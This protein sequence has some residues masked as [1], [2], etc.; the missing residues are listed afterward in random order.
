MGLL[1]VGP[2]YGAGCTA[3][4]DDDARLACFD[5]LAE[6]VTQ[7]DPERRLACY[8]AASARRAA[9]TP[10]PAAPARPAEAPVTRERRADEAFPVRGARDDEE[11]AE[12]RLVAE[13][14]EVRSDPRGLHYLTLDNG[15][16]WREL[17]KGR[18][19][20]EEGDRVEITPGILGSVNLKVE[21]R[22]GYV[23]VRRVE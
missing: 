20:F 21:G 6:C 5:R 23:K 13:I 12:E 16:I 4:A 8:D 7:H 3:E 11:R 1:M 17:S 9:A 10:A 14:V 2:A 22:S 18:I 19:R 15:Q